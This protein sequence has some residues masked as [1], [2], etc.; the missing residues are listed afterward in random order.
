[1]KTFRLWLLN[2]KWKCRN[3]SKFTLCKAPQIVSSFHLYELGEPKALTQ[4]T[5]RV[6]PPLSLLLSPCFPSEP[7]VNGLHMALTELPFP[8]GAVA[9]KTPC[10]VVCLTSS[11][12]WFHVMWSTLTRNQEDPPCSTVE[13]VKH[14][15]YNVFFKSGLCNWNL[16]CLLS[17]W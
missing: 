7:K 16:A 14:Q 1:M 5:E 12:L 13:N 6:L 8:H 11:W 2:A 3:T 10:L 9:A 15:A 4:T 17:G